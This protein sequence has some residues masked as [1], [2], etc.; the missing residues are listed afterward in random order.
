M[1]TTV[2]NITAALTPPRTTM[3]ATLIP[4]G[5]VN[6][7]PLRRR[8]Q[9]LPWASRSP[10]WRQAG[11]GGVTT[12]LSELVPYDRDGFRSEG[13]GLDHLQGE[14]NPT[15]VGNHKATS[16]TA[17]PRRHPPTAGS[18]TARDHAVMYRDPTE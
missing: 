14:R 5:D 9:E 12:L 10:V 1:A 17:R 16:P 11:Y 6:P 15:K 2:T 8:R 4:L 13:S 18:V 7:L 3:T